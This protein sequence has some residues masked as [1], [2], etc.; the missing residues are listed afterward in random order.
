M[1]AADSRDIW[2]SAIIYSQ[3]LMIPWEV[4]QQ[5]N[6]SNTSLFVDVGVCVFGIRAR[7]N[8]TSKSNI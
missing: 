8:K 6:E 5:C 7:E 2:H 3:D 4:C 1:H